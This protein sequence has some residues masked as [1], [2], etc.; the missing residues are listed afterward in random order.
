M[1]HDSLIKTIGAE[2]SRCVIRRIGHARKNL[3]TKQLCGF[4]IADSLAGS[5]TEFC[6]CS[7]WSELVRKHNDPAID[8][9]VSLYEYVVIGYELIAEQDV[10]RINMSS[11]WILAN[12]LRAI[13]AGRNFQL[14]ADVTGNFCNRSVDLLEFLVT[15]I[16]CQDNVLCLS[17]IP[18]AT[19][20]ELFYKLSYDDLRPAVDYLCKVRPCMNANC[21]CC[22]LIRELLAEK[23]IVE[24]IPS[25]EFTAQKLL[26]QTAMC[27]NFQ[28]FCNFCRA[29]LEI[30]PI[31]CK[32]HAK[33]KT[34]SYV[35]CVCFL[36]CGRQVSLHHSIPMSGTFPTKM[37]T[38]RF[39]ILLS[40]Y[41]TLGWRASQPVLRL[42]WLTTCAI[43]MGMGLPIGVRRLGRRHGDECVL[44]IVGML[45]ATTTSKLKCPCATSRSFYLKTAH[46][47][48]S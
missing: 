28:G 35:C 24:Y 33:F 48:S 46:W 43:T 6:I 1:L 38:A 34:L 32:P 16:P 4:M 21:K 19:E 13:V 11:V 30:D 9:D 36:S 27:D 2:H 18:K 37:R 5:L 45:D 12:A 41:V 8:Y 15:S 31:L 23:N 40:I 25:K 20:S 17:I 7:S 26:L 42:F 44:P 3:M 10:V 39:T 14:C 22:T 47:G 29:E